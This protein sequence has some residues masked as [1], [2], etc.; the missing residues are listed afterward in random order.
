M[1]ANEALHYA[2]DEAVADVV[3]RFESCSCALEEFTHARHITVAVWYLS[4]FP[5]EMAMAKMRSALINFSA[6]HNKMGYNETV[7]RFWL[8]LV[9]EFVASEKAKS[10]IRGA[11]IAKL[12]NAAVEFGDKNILFRY[13]SRERVSSEEARQRWLEPDLLAL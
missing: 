9:A 2:N 11:S 1:N 8:I 7:T 13:Y 10:S 5:L 4:K 6:H 3:E 12:A